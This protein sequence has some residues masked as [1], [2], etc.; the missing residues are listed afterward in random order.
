MFE[1]IFLKIVVWIDEWVIGKTFN[2]D[3]IDIISVGLD[4]ILQKWDILDKNIKLSLG[5]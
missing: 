2:F 4:N 5:K 1:I 3:C